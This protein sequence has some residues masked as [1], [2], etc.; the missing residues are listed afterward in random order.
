VEAYMAL[1]TASIISAAEPDSTDVPL[2]HT[3]SRLK[4]LFFYST[5]ALLLPCSLLLCTEYLLR[6]VN[7]GYD[8]AFFRRVRAQEGTNAIDNPDFGRRFFPSGLVRMPDHFKIPL[9]KEE[10][11]RRIF[12][13]GS[14]AALGDPAPAF[15]FSRN[16]DC[17]LKNRY[18]PIRCEVVNTAIT[19]INSHIVLPIARECSRL[20]PDIFI[21]YTGNNE[22][23]GPFGPGTVFSAYSS[24]WLIRLR[25]FLTSTRLGQAASALSRSIGHDNGIP[26]EWGGMKMFMAHK[27]RNNDTRLDGV[28]RNYRD[29]LR[30][31]CTTARRSGAR[32]V[33]CTIASNLAG[34]GPFVSMHR[35]DMLPTDTARWE[36]LYQQAA[37]LLQNGMFEAAL[38]RFSK[39][40]V[41][42]STHAGMHYLT[43]RCLAALG[44]HAEAKRH[45]IAARD[46]DALRFR[47]DSRI[48]AI[49]KD[50][51]R[52]F[53]DC[54]VIADI[55]DSLNSASVYGCS[56]DS[57]FLEH[58]HFNFRG[59][60]LVA[61]NLLTIV[62]SLIGVPVVDRR[63][64]TEAECRDRLA[65]TPWEEYWIGQEIY[66]RL[67]K[68]PFSLQ[69]NNQRSLRMLSL[70]NQHIFSLLSD[71]ADTILARYQKAVSLMPDDWRIHNQYAKYLLLNGG[72]P[73]LAEEAFCRSLQLMPQNNSA[74]IDLAIT[75]ERE[76]RTDEAIELYKAVIRDTPL[77][78][79]AYNSLADDLMQHSRI[80][81]AA[82]VVKK[83]LHINPDNLFAQERYA[84]L[85]FIGGREAV[86]VRLAK[87]GTLSR[88][89]LASCYYKDGQRYIE[90]GNDSAALD[91][92]SR[93]VEA[94]P[95][96][97]DAR[98]NLGRIL[99]KQKHYPEA[100]SHFRA[101]LRIDSTGG[102]P[103][104]LELA[105]A[106]AAANRTDD[107][108]A[109]Y[110]AILSQ[111][112]GAVPALNGLGMIFTK[113]DSIPEAIV[114]FM[115]AIEVQPS[116]LALQNNLIA[117]CA[118]LNRKDSAIT[119]L[120][121]VA[122]RNPGI[123]E[124]NRTLGTLLRE[125]GNTT[126]AR[127]Y[128]AIA[129]RIPSGLK[130]TEHPLNQGAF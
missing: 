43:A 96:L 46:Y 8:P 67:S 128:L 110:R 35:A 99:V 51:A 86:A 15:S 79:D 126:K 23:I 57:L 105:N 72:S 113:Q 58:V 125:Y 82:K 10:N 28:Y 5:T 115:R 80:D 62:D 16:L 61:E 33:L 97:M 50:V 98:I 32:A 59:N 104:R 65:Y 64:L 1:K 84:Q 17:M 54:A 36:E 34:C 75:L 87:K 60:H 9:R 40:A 92:F 25:I 44:R 119:L 55:E 116:A 4:R 91:R 19:A 93:A 103:V 101:A 85:L 121:P 102:L 2:P 71:S 95:D 30:E 88:Q 106:L 68:P 37:E 112:P 118:F 6:A 90:N 41:I 26:A 127:H 11:S 38:D 108:K 7:F 63:T 69:V 117:A 52:E 53:S 81:E 3:P 129:A 20:S 31:I 111:D 130:E 47:A 77:Y 13:L 94:H 18:G 76:G 107:A 48:N 100:I 66:Q 27:F 89:V 109:A 56:G 123:P 29:N 70:N 49:I 22:V 39:T 124:I 120:S 14:S 42:D 21:V 45:F 114:L 74:R 78:I 73:A 12:I 83:A 24:R 122:D